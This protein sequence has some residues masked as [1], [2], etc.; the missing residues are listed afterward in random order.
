MIVIYS[1]LFLIDDE[2]NRYN[3]S[4]N[5]NILYIVGEINYG[6]AQSMVKKLAYE[7]IDVV[8]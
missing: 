7:A 1:I 6:E 2:S 3:S 5:S 4:S 8:I